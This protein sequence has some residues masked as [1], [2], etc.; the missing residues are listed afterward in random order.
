[1]CDTEAIWGG[2]VSHCNGAEAHAEEVEN[3]EVMTRK[4]GS[5]K[6]DHKVRISMA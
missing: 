6:E 5:N 2:D 1:M 4:A 3:I